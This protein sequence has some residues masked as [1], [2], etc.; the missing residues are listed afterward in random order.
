MIFM[1]EHTQEA[2]LIQPELGCVCRRCRRSG[3]RA[4]PCLEQSGRHRAQRRRLFQVTSTARRGGRRT[5]AAARCPT[6]ALAAALAQQLHS[7][8]AHQQ[9][10][11]GAVAAPG[12]PEGSDVLALDACVHARGAAE[13][14]HAGPAVPC[15][16]PTRYATITKLCLSN[17]MYVAD[18]S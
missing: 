16:N 14:P 6:P 10:Q 8:A 5:V 15:V 7:H 2:V 17:C 13:P 3:C 12:V 9:R 18:L 11:P 1:L 4:R